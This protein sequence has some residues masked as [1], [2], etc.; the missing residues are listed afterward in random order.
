MKVYESAKGRHVLG[1]RCTRDHG[2]NH[3]LYRD[4]RYAECAGCGT[5]YGVGGMEFDSRAEAEAAERAV[6]G[7]ASTHWPWVGAD[8]A[9]P[10]SAVADH[11]RR[12]RG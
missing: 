10:S 9:V 1:H 3:R 7:Y 5:F 12:S 11:V 4:G 8:K 2:G 6:K